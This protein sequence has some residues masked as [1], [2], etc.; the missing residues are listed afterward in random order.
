MKR[1]S[2]WALA[3]F[4]LTPQETWLS[5]QGKKNET[6]ALVRIILLPNFL[7]LHPQQS[8]RVGT[9]VRMTFLSLSMSG[10]VSKSLSS[11]ELS[12]SEWQGCPPS[13]EDICLPGL[14]LDSS[15]T[16]N[17]S[18]FKSQE[19]CTEPIPLQR[20]QCSLILENAMFVQMNSL[21]TRHAPGLPPHFFFFSPILYLCLP[22]SRADGKE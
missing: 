18:A 7:L 11:T 17:S 10:M 6:E 15:E 22:V 21:P 3:R 2:S 1:L 12:V 20:V 9:L 4:H 13:E 8:G 19:W 5:L 16:E 14:E